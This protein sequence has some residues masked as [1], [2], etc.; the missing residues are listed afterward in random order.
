MEWTHRR[1]GTAAT[2]IIAAALMAPRVGV[3]QTVDLGARAG[4]YSPIGS[5]IEGPP[6][7]KR[8]QG[9]VMGGLDAVVWMSGRVGFAAG[10]AYTPSRVAVIQPGNVTDRDASV[11]LA[12]ARVLFALT[13]L[14]NGA[15]TDPPWSI[16]V[17]AGPGLAHRSGGVWAYQSGAT[18]PALVLN[19]GV[20]T[21]SGPRV[22]MRLDFEDSISR[23]QFDAGAPGETAAQTHHDLAFSISLSYRVH[24]R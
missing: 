21:L 9:A 3:A 8:L 19:A 14:G 16:Y 2:L 1:G 18:S 12:S 17:G 24:R 22:V 10:V 5:L 20:E 11:I 4:F 6:I 15:A 13:P 7:Q 23:A